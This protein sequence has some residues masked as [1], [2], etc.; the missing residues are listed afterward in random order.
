RLQELMQSEAVR[1]FEARAR[2][3][4]PSFT[5]NAQNAEA[6]AQICQRLDG[7]PL[8][9][10]LA[11]A[12]VNVLVPKQIAERLDNSLRLLTRSA[13][14]SPARHQTLRAALDWSFDLLSPA[15]Q[16][17]FMRLAVFAGSFGVDAVEAI[18][19]GD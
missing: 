4:V 12:R 17:F 3:V 7:M 5:L 13:H 6:V 18:C 10:E 16:S 19:E 9:I 11:A 15:E 14:P 1:L 8:A 2:L